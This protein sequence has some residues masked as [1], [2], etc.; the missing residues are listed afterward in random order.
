MSDN[1]ALRALDAPAP[2][3]TN[4]PPRVLV[5]TP[6][7]ASKLYALTQWVEHLKAQ[8]TDLLWDVLIIDNTDTPPPGYLDWLTKWVKSK[9]FGKGHRVRL[10]RFGLDADGMRFRNPLYKVQWAERI[11]IERFNRW[12]SY[13][14]LWSV[15]CDVLVPPNALQALYESGYAWAAAWMV[16]RRMFDPNRAE[17]RTFPLVFTDL[18]LDV[19]RTA[20]DFDDAVLRGGGITE[21]P[22]PD[23]FPV[24]VTHLGCTFL[25]GEVVRRVP[26]ELSMAGGDVT[27]SWAFTAAGHPPHVV[28]AV[29]CEHVAHWE[30]VGK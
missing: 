11:A 29:A 28:P 25:R 4:R 7:I 6:I 1:P 16:T 22:G 9:P 17:I 23:P 10:V 24:A 12:G 18:T 30:A 15:E 8:E 27:Y 14:H 3:P 26:F 5:F 21:P 13:D 19:Y 20:Q 2:Q